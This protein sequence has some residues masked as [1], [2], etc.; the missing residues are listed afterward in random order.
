MKSFSQD[1]PLS[2]EDLIPGGKTFYKYRAEMPRQISWYG[3]L[4]TYAKGDSILIVPQKENQKP[5]ALITLDAM[6]QKLGLE[7]S[8][9]LKSIGYVSAMYGKSNE[10]F[11]SSPN[12]NTYLLN[13]VTGVTTGKY[14]TT[15][16]MENRD[17]SIQNRTF[18]YTK[19]NNLYIQTKD[20]SEHAITSETDKGIVYGQS[21]HRNEFGIQKG[22]FWSPKGNLLAFYRMDQTMVT[23]YPLVDISTRIAELKDIKYPMAGMKSHQVTVGV[24]DLK[25]GKTVYLKTGTPKEKYLT[26]IAWSPDEKYIYIAELNRGQDTC[27]LKSYD[28]LTGNLKSTLFTEIHPKY[29]EPENPV[30]FLKNDS[31]KFLW[32]SKRDGFN[33]LYLYDISGKLIKQITEGEW[34]VT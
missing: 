31:G 29:V 3:D 4:L 34:D 32:T 26:N 5:Q 1:I 16:D 7:N 28:V 14:V 2:L 10:L 25:D 6:N 13:I 21:A 30:M 20:G 11:I 8:K 23:D 9:T 27:V 18:A 12:D 24:Y 17:F 22:I 19:D 33:H 15:K